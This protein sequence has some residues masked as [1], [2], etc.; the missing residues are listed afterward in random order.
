MRILLLLSLL[1]TIIIG[2]AWS[3]TAAAVYVV[4]VKNDVYAFAHNPVMGD[5][6]P[7]FVAGPE[8]WLIV[9]DKRGDK[10]KVDDMNGHIGWIDKSVVEP[11]ISRLCMTSGG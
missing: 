9:L 6:K 7:V 1:L 3:Q 5:E 2:S 4:T 8:E 10:L 11:N